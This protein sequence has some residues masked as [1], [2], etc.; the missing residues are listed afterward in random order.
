MTSA[1]G[2]T[3]ELVGFIACIGVA[4]MIARYQSSMI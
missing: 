3:L 4:F 2:G 1:L